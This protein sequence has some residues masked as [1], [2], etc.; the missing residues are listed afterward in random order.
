[1]RLSTSIAK[2]ALRGTKVGVVAG[3]RGEKAWEQNRIDAREMIEWAK[4]GAM[5]M[6]RNVIDKIPM[7]ES[8]SEP[9]H[10][11]GKH[12]RATSEDPYPHLVVKDFLE[13]LWNCVKGDISLDDLKPAR[14]S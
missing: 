4:N 2:V 12:C 3:P 1:M 7:L 8:V 11:V 14:K 13:S 6:S 5:T 10:S 9:C